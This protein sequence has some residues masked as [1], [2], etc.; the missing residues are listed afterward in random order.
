MLMVFKIFDYR[1]SIVQKI[2]N[3]TLWI[4]IHILSTRA[5]FR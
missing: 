3:F 4:H 1:T 2:L 5:I